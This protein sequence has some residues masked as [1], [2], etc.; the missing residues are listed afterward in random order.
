MLIRRRD[1]LC[2]QVLVGLFFRLFG[3]L[4]G[5]PERARE[6]IR[7]GAPGRVF[8]FSSDA[9]VIVIWPVVVQVSRSEPS[10]CPSSAER[11]AFPSA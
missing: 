7:G 4:W 2:K 8:S 1:G 6:D 5:G 11:R 10:A 9:A 3:H